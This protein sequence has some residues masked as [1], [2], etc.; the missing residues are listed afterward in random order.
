MENGVY[1][2]VHDTEC[3]TEANCLVHAVKSVL[4]L[5]VKAVTWKNQVQRG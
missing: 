5:P 2:R 3:Y 4:L 1:C